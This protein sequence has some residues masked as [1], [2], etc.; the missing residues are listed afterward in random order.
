MTSF[1]CSDLFDLSADTNNKFDQKSQLIGEMNII[2]KAF[3]IKVTIL[4][5]MQSIY[6]DFFLLETKKF[7]KFVLEFVL[8]NRMTQR[9]A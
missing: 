2:I 9:K 3:Q 8:L 4:F 7:R 5:V 6:R 1:Q